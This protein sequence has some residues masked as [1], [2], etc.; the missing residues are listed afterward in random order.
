MIDKY[1]NYKNNYNIQECNFIFSNQANFTNFTTRTQERSCRLYNALI[2][3]KSTVNQS[4]VNVDV[5][6]CVAGG[7]EGK[8]RYWED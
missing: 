1:D 3:S 5:V 6:V 8:R 4:V 7:R 2:K